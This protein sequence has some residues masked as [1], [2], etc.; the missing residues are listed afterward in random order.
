M[1][2]FLREL[3]TDQLT[4]AV[5]YAI[6]IIKHVKQIKNLRLGYAIEG[7]SGE[8]TSDERHIGERIIDEIQHVEQ[9]D[10]IVLPQEIAERYIGDLAPPARDTERETSIRRTTR[11]RSVARVAQ[12][13]P[14]LRPPG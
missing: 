4:G 2:D 12:A 5:Y 8:P 11:R 1:F 13:P 10:L 9:T 7:V 14:R 3:P 6:R